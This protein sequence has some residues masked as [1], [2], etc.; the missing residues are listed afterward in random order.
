[1]AQ[2]NEIRYSHGNDFLKSLSKS[3]HGKAY[4]DKLEPCPYCEPNCGMFETPKF[5]TEWDLEGIVVEIVFVRNVSRFYKKGHAMMIS[6]CPRCK[7]L[8]F[9]HTGIN[10]LL[11][12]PWV[13]K[14]IVQAEIDAWKQE[15]IDE[16]NRSLCKICTVEKT[17]DKNDYGYWVECSSESGYSSTSPRQPDEKEC[18]KCDRF[19]KQ[20]E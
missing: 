3:T 15:T 17:V 11:R 18:Y 7:K 2:E 10:R 1:M 8:S 13:N 6:K 4:R 16:W 14:E 20:E 9:R 12:K 19:I 5:A